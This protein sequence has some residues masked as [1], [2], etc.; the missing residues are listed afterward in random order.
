[1]KILILGSAGQI[2]GHLVEYIEQRTSHEAI[3]HDIVDGDEF[4]L[5]RRQETFEEHFESCD[6]VVFLAF[7]VGGATYLEKYQHTFDFANNNMCMMANVFDLVGRAGKPVLFASSQ[8]ST[9]DWSPYGMLKRA[10]ELYTKA[11]DGVVVRLWN[12]Y[13]REHDEEKFHVITDFIK[14]AVEDGHIAMRT[15]GEESRQFLHADDCCA[16]FLH[17]IENYETIDRSAPFHL[18]SFEWTAIR[19]L[20]EMV[21]RRVPGTT[22]EAGSRADAVQGVKVEPERA[23]LEHWQPRISLE[24]GIAGL[25][26]H[27]STG[28]GVRS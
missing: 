24:D 21:A 20:A 1:M 11:V 7:D 19:D 15:D 12:V 14:M 5:R 26:E 9:M 6:I 27:Y 2:G 16:A 28:D 25:V 23:I 18:S 13:G 8:M 17:F 4:D 3:R 22:I 10:G